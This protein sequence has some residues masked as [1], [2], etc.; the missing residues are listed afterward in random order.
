MTTETDTSLLGEPAQVDTAAPTDAPANADDAGQKV[1]PAANP[2]EAKDDTKPEGAPEAY[3]PFTMPEGVELDTELLGEFSPV[4]KELN[5]PQAAAQKVIDFAPKLI[6]KTTSTV[7]DAVGMA[8][9]HEWANTAKADKELGGEKFAENLSVA[10]KAMDAFGTPE[11]RVVLNK[12]GLGN[13]PEL[14]RAFYRAGKQISEDAFMP[15]G[16]TKTV[17]NP[18]L[19]IFDKSNMNP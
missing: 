11:L 6:E 1:E 2:E 18:A 17:S 9:R 14:L 7:L 10:K 8:D 5:L 19:G 16:K 3:E 12:T 13:H 15:G 4:L